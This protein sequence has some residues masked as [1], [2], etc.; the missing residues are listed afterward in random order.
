M[1]TMTYSYMITLETRNSLRVTS[2]Y[3][4]SKILALKSK[5]L[6]PEVGLEDGG[7]FVVSTETPAE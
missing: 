2:A 5:S 4:W 1:Q 7:M 3:E 6:H